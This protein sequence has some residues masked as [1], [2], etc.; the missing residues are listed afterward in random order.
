MISNDGLR[1]KEAGWDSTIDT[2]RRDYPDDIALFAFMYDRPT[3]RI[4]F[5]DG[6]GQA[7]LAVFPAITRKMFDVLGYLMPSG[8]HP[9]VCDPWLNEVA[10]RARRFRMIRENH[11][12]HI[13]R[14]EYDVLARHQRMPVAIDRYK[15]SWRYRVDDAKRL[16]DA[17]EEAGITD[18][19][20]VDRLRCR[21]GLAKPE[22]FIIPP[23]DVVPPAHVVTFA[24]DVQKALISGKPLT[25][26]HG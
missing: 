9:L 21:P 4:K 19:S 5:D 23:H 12:T 11:T 15:Q 17:I 1:F 6:E 22:I 14:Y 10:F 3:F 7:P 18:P 13:Q 2:Y 16:I 20:T 8:A 25:I 26:E 24:D